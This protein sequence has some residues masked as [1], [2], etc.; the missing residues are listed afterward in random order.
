MTKGLR[1]AMQRQVAPNPGFRDFVCIS[2]LLIWCTNKAR[3]GGHT[4]VVP[5]AALCWERALRQDVRDTSI[6]NTD[7]RHEVPEEGFDAGN[8]PL[9]G[10]DR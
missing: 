6:G 8:D 9:V 2:A 10:P 4:A 7:M 1:L 5:D 3:M